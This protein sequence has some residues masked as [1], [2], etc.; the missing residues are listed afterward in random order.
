[1]AIEEKDLQELKREV[2]ESRN[3]VIKQDNQ[4]K[5]LH[6]ELKRLNELWQGLARRS[7]A[8]TA[9][10]YILFVT[11]ALVLA[12]LFANARIRGAE[13]RATAAEA[14]ESVALAN[15]KTVQS[16][17][18]AER[19]ASQRALELFE[20]LAGKDPTARAAAIEEVSRL[21][22]D[23][24]ITRLEFRWLQEKS[25]ELRRAA[26]IDAVESGRAAFN[27]REFREA[28][29]QLARHVLIAPDKPEETALLLLGQT[30]HQLRMW[31]EAIEPLE[32]WLAQN[33]QN[34]NGD[35]VT[36]LLGE[37]LTE[38]GEKARAIEVYKT[39][40][41]KFYGTNYGAWMRTRAR[42]LELADRPLPGGQGGVPA[43]APAPPAPAPAPN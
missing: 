11:F 28:E 40:A 36:L 5:N 37:A 3:L 26:A 16:R 43:P 18:E 2:I 20:R 23:L 21:S 15:L 27:R 14:K 39:G 22:S 34:K 17:A 10:A 13:E 24:P 1:M 9:T 12:Y 31:K 4:I 41:D 25:A 7:V 8:S 6:A 30:R 42:K 33:P 19:V 32:G 35:Y 38:A 29:Q